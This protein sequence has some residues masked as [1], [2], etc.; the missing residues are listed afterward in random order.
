MMRRRSFLKLSGIAVPGLAVPFSNPAGTERSDKGFAVEN[1]K[2]RNDAPITLL[3]G[4]VFY[5]KI[6]TADTDGDVFTFESTRKVMADRH[7]III[8]IRMNG[9]I[10][11]PE[12]LLSGSGTI[13]SRR[14]RVILRSHPEKFLMLL[15][16]P[17]KEKRGC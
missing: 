16:R 4:D 7:C 5:T 14:K 15:A 8:R 17:A 2:D 9:F 1:G 11:F 10:F 6:G 3:E 12:N 13:R